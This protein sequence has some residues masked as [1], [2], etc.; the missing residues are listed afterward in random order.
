MCSCVPRAG[1]RNGISIV[2]RARF[3][4]WIYEYGKSV[5]RFCGHIGRWPFVVLRG[6]RKGS[7]LNDFAQIYLHCAN[8]PEWTWHEK[9]FSVVRRKNERFKNEKEN[10]SRERGE[11][12]IPSQ[13]SQFFSQHLMLAFSRSKGSSAVSTCPEWD[14]VWSSASFCALY[15]SKA[16]MRFFFEYSR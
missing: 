10:I 5:R 11:V 9:Q 13:S 3:C 8:W 12:N 2:A 4:G 16:G 6:L 1:G 14:V 7:V 15:G